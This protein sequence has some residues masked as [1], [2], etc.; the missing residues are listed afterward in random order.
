MSSVSET[1]RTWAAGPVVED[2]RTRAGL[3]VLGF[4]L[5]TSFGAQVAVPLPWTQVPMT[6]QP[7]FVI[8][9]GAMLGPRLGA[10]AMAAYVALG[11]AGAPVF[12]FGG[13]GLAWLMGPTGGY[14]LAA[15]AAA[16]VVGSVARGEA[17]WLRTATALTLGV[18]TMYAGGLSQLLIL[19]GQG[20]T[21][22]L[23]L[24]VLPFLVGD[25]TK[26]LVAL[27]LVK[28]VQPKSLGR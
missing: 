3:G 26:I 19:T 24:A 2:R 16:Y 5:V 21:E 1:L 9:A 14:L 4:V 8:L 7:L 23:A 28:G 18:V 6:L 12:A 17:G 15:P 13:F 25:I 27:V 20:L 10:F 11:A 22:V